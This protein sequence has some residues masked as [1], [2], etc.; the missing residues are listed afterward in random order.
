VIVAIA[1]G[2]LRVSGGIAAYFLGSLLELL[3]SGAGGAVGLLKRRC[4]RW[5]RRS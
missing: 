2:A 5:Q 1:A 3:I 4:C